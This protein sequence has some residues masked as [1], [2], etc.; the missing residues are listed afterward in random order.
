MVC[1]FR[2]VSLKV[3]SAHLTYYYQLLQIWHDGDS[4]YLLQ[5][6]WIRV[7]YAS[8]LSTKLAIV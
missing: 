1:A 8:Q 2:N 6:A 5:G 4:P 3:C 7:L